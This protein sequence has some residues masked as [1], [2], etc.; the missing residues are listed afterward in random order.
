MNGVVPSSGSWIIAFSMSILILMCWDEE[1]EVPPLYCLLCTE[2]C[3]AI[4][5]ELTFESSS[6]IC[7][8]IRVSWARRSDSISSTIY[9]SDLELTEITNVS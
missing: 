4:L 8:S 1:F 7:F 5:T 3:I 2:L 6:L 9:V